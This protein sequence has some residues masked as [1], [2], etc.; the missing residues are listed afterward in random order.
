MGRATVA[1]LTILLVGIVGVSHAHS[2]VSEE[3]LAAI[4]GMRLILEKA[5][6]LE[7]EQHRE[8]LLNGFESGMA[9]GMTMNALEIVG[10]LLSRSEELYTQK[11]QCVFWENFFPH[12]LVE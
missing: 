4:H 1:A 11:C 5:G 7:L 6:C 8:I 9:R 2:Q 12:A 3:D 10:I